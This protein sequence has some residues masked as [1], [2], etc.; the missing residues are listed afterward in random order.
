MG[1][2]MRRVVRVVKVWIRRE[3]GRG[4]EVADGDDEVIL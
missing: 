1:G 3:G 2:R 4:E